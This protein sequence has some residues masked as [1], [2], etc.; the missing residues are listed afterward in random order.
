MKEF[1]SELEDKPVPED[2]TKRVNFKADM[3]NQ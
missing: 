1:I 2:L 3:Q